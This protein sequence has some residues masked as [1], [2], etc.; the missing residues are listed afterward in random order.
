MTILFGRVSVGQ[1]CRVQLRSAGFSLS[2]SQ[3]LTW[4]GWKLQEGFTHKSGTFELHVASFP[5]LQ[6]APSVPT[7]VSHASWLPKEAVKHVKEDASLLGPSPGSQHTVTS[8][9][10]I[11]RRNPVL[12]HIQG[13]GTYSLPPDGED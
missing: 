2:S 13:E 5:V 6:Q 12:S 3:L 4:L 9:V 7:R 10:R 8:T 11:V 1:E